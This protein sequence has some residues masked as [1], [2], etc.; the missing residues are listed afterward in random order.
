[1]MESKTRELIATLIHCSNRDPPSPHDVMLC[2]SEKP[3][4]T[5]V[6]SFIPSFHSILI[7]PSLPPFTPSFLFTFHSNSQWHRSN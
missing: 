7:P 1:M 3:A 2:L 4:V 5:F 6:S